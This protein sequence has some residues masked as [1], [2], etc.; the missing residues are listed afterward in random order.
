M[1]A[2]LASKR[3]SRFKISSMANETQWIAFDGPICI[4][5]G[6]PREMAGQVKAYFESHPDASILFFDAATS[7]QIH[8]DLRVD[9]EHLVR[10]VEYLC[11][12]AVHA[13][14]SDGQKPS[15][16]SREIRLLARH[17]EWLDTQPGGASVALRK[18]VEQ[19]MRT[20]GPADARRAAQESAYRFMTAMAGD[21]R[22]YEEA[23]RALYKGDR[24]RLVS[25]IAP[26]P[27]DIRAHVLVLL[28]PVFAA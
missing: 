20:S 27:E 17:W 24:T 14:A 10:V 2:I 9:S 5:R 18:L 11:K 3:P 7:R 19:A 12:P 15:A 26:W 8:I 13:V 16:M 23:I 6:K 21:E 1:F 25:C 4:A 28:E 22:D